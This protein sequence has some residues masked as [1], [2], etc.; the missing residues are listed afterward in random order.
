HRAAAE[1]GSESFRGRRAR[2]GARQRPRDPLL[3]RL[4]RE[5]QQQVEDR[6][7]RPRRRAKVGGPGRRQRRAGGLPLP[8]GNRAPPGLASGPLQPMQPPPLEQMTVA[9]A[10]E[11]SPGRAAWLARGGL[12]ALLLFV[13]PA[14]VSVLA[15]RYA[16][17]SRLAGAGGGVAGF[18]SWVADRH[19]L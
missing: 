7:G 3:P 16:F 13:G 18:F 11:R 4:P 9:V 17:P 15:L 14:V 8:R 10:P 1:P 6:L 12:R 19:P 5:G 2:G